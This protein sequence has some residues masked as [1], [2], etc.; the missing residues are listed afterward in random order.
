MLERVE[1]RSGA[2]EFQANQ[3][4]TTR[5]VTGP[6]ETDHPAPVGHKAA[7]IGELHWMGAM[8]AFRLA[9]ALDAQPQLPS[10][11]NDAF[12]HQPKGGFALTPDQ[13]IAPD[14]T[15]LFELSLVRPVSD[16]ASNRND[17]GALRE[18]S[19]LEGAVHHFGGSTTVAALAWEA[20]KL[21]GTHQPT[22]PKMRRRSD[23]GTLE[24]PGKP[25]IFRGRLMRV[26]KTSQF[27]ERL[28][29]LE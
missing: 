7:L 28:P 10:L 4:S 14:S 12:D 29:G 9:L 21:S 3:S 11:R 27:V 15:R 17:T 1:F 25:V 22:V 24:T 20:N 26:G 6:N 8:N 5:G 23:Q 19:A 16:L 2:V 18:R 13:G